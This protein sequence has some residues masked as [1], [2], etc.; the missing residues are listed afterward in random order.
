MRAEARRGVC[1]RDSPPDVECAGRGANWNLAT[2]TPC[3]VSGAAP[4]RASTRTNAVAP[5]ANDAQLSFPVTRGDVARCWDWQ[6]P[7]AASGG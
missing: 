1:C 7:F 4:R 3:C 6:A 2:T 5:A